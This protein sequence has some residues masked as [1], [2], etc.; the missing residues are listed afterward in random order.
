MRAKPE[1]TES[2]E[3]TK[4]ERKTKI[5]QRQEIAALWPENCG[6]KR[7]DKTSAN[8]QGGA[9]QAIARQ[10]RPEAAHHFR[11][12]KQNTHR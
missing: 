6:P 1:G 2:K 4:R 9:A 7:G 11:A 3:L 10:H 8:E 12:R 5:R